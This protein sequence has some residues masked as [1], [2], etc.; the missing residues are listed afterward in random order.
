MRV[1]ATARARAPLSRESI[2]V[3]L[4]SQSAIVNQWAKIV[5][6]NFLCFVIPAI[7]LSVFVNTHNIEVQLS[8]QR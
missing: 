7:I 6:Y 4:T 8:I 1:K 3:K 5:C 2:M